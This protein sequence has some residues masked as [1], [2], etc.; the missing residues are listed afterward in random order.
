MCR[1][2]AFVFLVAL[3]ACSGGTDGPR[4]GGDGDSDLDGDTDADAGDGDS[5][6]G[7]DG[8][9]V[10]DAAGGG[11]G[12]S[13][14]RSL[15]DDLGRLAIGNDVH[16]VGHKGG[17]LVH[18]R[19]DDDGVTWGEPAVIAPASGNFPAMYG[20]L[21]ALGATVYLLTAP[22][23]MDS[24]AAAGGRDLDFRKS[25]N[26]GADWSGPRRI[27]S[28]ALIFRV[29]IVASGSY[30]HVVGTTNPTTNAALVYLRSIDGGDNWEETTLATDLGQY[31][32]GQ[33]VAVD[34]AVVHVAYTQAE[35]GPGGGPTFYRRST[36]NGENWSAPVPIGETSLESDR[37]ARV[38]LSAADGHVFA[39]W[40]REA[41]Y[42]G[43]AVP[44]DRIGYATS[45]NGGAAWGSAQI[46]PFDTGI[47]RNHHHVWLAPGGGVHVIWRH[48]DSGDTTDD[49]AG[50]LSSTD[51]GATWGSHDFAVDTR[52]VIAGA[53]H[54][55][56]VVA[57]DA[58]V[59][60]LTGP[61]G[62]MQ[63][64]RRPLK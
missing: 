17:D 39:I 35:D 6:G 14:P 40:Q 20:G 52:G 45:A 2:H 48:G 61:S 47:D 23:D 51:Y 7:G 25:V 43:G 63:Y 1:A 30:V 64:A 62:A 32:G 50:S 11:F 22:A 12:W 4:A 15:V 49:P 24:S 53:N 60:A 9:G 33:T 55:W 34:G 36:D 42:T 44:A 37:Q 16:I 10:G 5:A 8:D 3:A 13:A 31:G 29:R 57:D 28:T 41:L 21:Y 46:L 18:R 59:H 56:S 58:A 26:G 38:Q 19:S 27:T 54:P